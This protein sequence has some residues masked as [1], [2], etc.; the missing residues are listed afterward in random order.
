MAAPLP[1]SKQAVDLTSV[2]KVSRIR[3]D[4]PAKLKEIPLK[5]PDE[6]DRKAVMIGV[7]VF[8]LALFVIVLAVM[9]WSGWTPRSYVANV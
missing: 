5:D 3:R 4:P 6:V 7:T 1:T 8:A 9:M 2:E